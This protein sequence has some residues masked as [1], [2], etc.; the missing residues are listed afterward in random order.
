MIFSLQR[1]GR[2]GFVI[3]RNSQTRYE[4]LIAP[5]RFLLKSE[6][7]PELDVFL[8]DALYVLVPLLHIFLE[9]LE[10]SSQLELHVGCVLQ[11]V[12]LNVLFVLHLS[13][14]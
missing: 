3:I 14:G 2:L 11:V 10:I 12:V 13:Y 8:L 9:I 5:F 7:L 6:I 4:T 1:S